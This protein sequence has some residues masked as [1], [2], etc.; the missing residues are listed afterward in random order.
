MEGH[1]EGKGIM[2]YQDGSKYDGEWK[3]DKFNGKGLL[4]FAN[5]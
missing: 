4:T 5:C 2:L 3:K 1:K